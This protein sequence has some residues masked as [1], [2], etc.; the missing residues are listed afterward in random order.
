MKTF[1]AMRFLFSLAIL[2][3]FLGACNGTKRIPTHVD[4][5]VVD[6]ANQPSA[7]RE[8][9]LYS[10]IMAQDFVNGPDAKLV[11]VARSDKDGKA[12]FDYTWE[13][14]E[15]TITYF[16]VVPDGDEFNV[17]VS[18]AT[19]PTPSYNLSQEKHNVTIMVDKLLPLKLRTKSNRND[20]LAESSRVYIKDF[21]N[22][23]IKTFKS[24]IDGR[25]GSS[26]NPDPL[27]RVTTVR[28]L[29]NKACVLT[30]TL[31]YAAEPKTVAKSYEIDLRTF[32]DSVFL[33]QF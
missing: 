33:A 19:I 29:Q 18:Y 1:K 26:S 2:S 15:S 31:T 14:D 23:N 28:A 24:S 20:V 9:F 25:G 17:P 10:T 30:V 3:L 12:A 21:S 16:H 6:G 4:V 8:V 7:N 27:D 22:G 5:L 11:G 13:S 32:R